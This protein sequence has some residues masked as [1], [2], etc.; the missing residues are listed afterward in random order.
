MYWA[1]VY[2]ACH[3]YFSSLLSPNFPKYVY[4]F[5][6]QRIYT[7]LSASVGQLPIDYQAMQ[8]NGNVYLSSLHMLV[9]SRAT[10]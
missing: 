5:K 8:K 7:V 4:P 6:W 10:L 1:T 3:L 9:M 2:W